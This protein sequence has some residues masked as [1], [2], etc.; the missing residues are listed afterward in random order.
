MPGSREVGAS[1][2]KLN[3]CLIQTKADAAQTTRV[4]PR[5]PRGTYSHSGQ[6]LPPRCDDGQRICRVR[7]IDPGVR[8]KGDRS[9]DLE[10]DSF[11]GIPK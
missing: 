4:T 11:V 7:V 3:R 8:R 2:D 10:E 6:G 5:R 1:P 9:D